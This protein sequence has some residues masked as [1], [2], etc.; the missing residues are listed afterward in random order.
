MKVFKSMGK[1]KKAL[2]QPRYIAVGILVLVALFPF[3]VRDP[4]ILH[5]GILILIW[6]AFS[7]A[8]NLLAGYAGQVS[9]GHAAF[10]GL[11]AYT[12]A[13]LY[14]RLEFPVLASLFA[15]GAVAMLFSIPIGLVCFRLRG[16]YFSLAVMAF[17]H[18]L[19]VIARNWR[20]FTE[21][22]V[23]IALPILPVSKAFYYYAALAMALLMLGV[24]YKVVHSKLGFYFVAIREDQD[25]AEALGIPTTKYKLIALVISAF[26]SGMIGAFFAYYMSYINPPIVFS[27]TDV[28][29]AVMLVTVFGGIG[30]IWGPA[31]GATIITIFSEITRIL[32]GEVHLMIYGALII[33]VMVF[34]PE[35]IAGGLRRLLGR[36]E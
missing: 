28:S 3:V 17:A 2:A 15:A 5:I 35:G 27:G 31:I 9:F 26:L 29:L 7:E 8:W 20:S 30:T 12:A 33:M 10:F 32:F 21:G 34:M 11:G 4:Y 36:R 25:A 13:L 6:F 14:T 18:V 1:A 23:G 24:L 16:V 19:R 22:A